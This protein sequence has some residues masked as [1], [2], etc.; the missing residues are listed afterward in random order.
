MKFQWPVLDDR[1]MRV[2]LCVFILAAGFVGGGAVCDVAHTLISRLAGHH[3]DGLTTAME[4]VSLYY[5]WSLISSCRR[6]VEADTIWTRVRRR[7]VAGA[8]FVGSA[9]TGVVVMLPGVL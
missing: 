2:V 3:V 9:L 4:V 7:R 6:A 1:V 5:L 8:L